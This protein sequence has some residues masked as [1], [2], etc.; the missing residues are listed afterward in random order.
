MQTLIVTKELNCFDWC[1]T[2]IM[3][4]FR[5]VYSYIWLS[6]YQFFKKVSTKLL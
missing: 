4:Y 1:N 6:R 5:A 3:L 2:F